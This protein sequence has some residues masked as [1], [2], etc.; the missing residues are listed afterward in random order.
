MRIT[1]YGV[2]GG[3][4]KSTICLTL[5]K[6]L[7]KKGKKVLVIDRDPLGWSSNIIGVKDKGLINSIIDGYSS[8]F[9]KS[10][11]IGDGYLDVIKFYGDPSRVFG[12]AAILGRDKEVRKRL[13]EVYS[14]LLINNKYDF[15]IVDNF[16]MIN[17]NDSIVFYE[18]E[19]FNKTL[20]AIDLFRLYISDHSI[21]TLKNTEKYIEII[22]KEANI[23]KPLGL[24][25]NMVP[26]YPKELEDIRIEVERILQ[27]K[28]LGIGVII[29][30]IE[31]LFGF[32]GTLNELDT[33][34]QIDKLAD[35]ILK[36]SLTGYIIS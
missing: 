9:F 34:T 17:Y 33:P 20:P 24:V 16:A 8:N 27:N 26:P 32:S 19:V 36:G 29:P 10:V 14:R 35:N 30:F 5:G 15:Y 7:A 11:K 2:K 3:I 4:G 6:A 12:D 28:K 22:E 21:T 25:V 1:V 31:K 13:E 18:R 23:G